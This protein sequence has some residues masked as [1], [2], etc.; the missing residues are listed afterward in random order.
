LYCASPEDSVGGPQTAGNPIKGREN[1]GTAPEMKKSMQPREWRGKMESYPLQLRQ[2]FFTE[3]A[4]KA[5]PSYR[6][7]SDNESPEFDVETNVS[8]AEIPERPDDYQVTL[9]LASS[10]REGRAMPYAFKLTTVGLFSVDPGHPDKTELAK[11][12]GASILSGAA[13]E[14]LFTLTG[15]GP[16][17]AI[18]LPAMAFD[19]LKEEPAIAKVAAGKARKARKTSSGRSSG[20]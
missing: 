12:T 17:R 3:I 19:E 20:R 18:Y 9:A 7:A 2:Y 8:I 4:L 6:E 1:L 14:F 10:P 16:W 13:R 5:I 15:R 11:V